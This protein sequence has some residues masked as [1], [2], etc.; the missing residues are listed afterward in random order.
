MLSER[1]PFEAPAV[2]M[3]AQRG[4]PDLAA[5]PHPLPTPLGPGRCTLKW[6]IQKMKQ[7][8]GGKTEK[9]E[10]GGK[11]QIRQNLEND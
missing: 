5:R 10:I 6:S 4:W 8:N 7:Y 9:Q 11:G 3:I 2:D 1:A